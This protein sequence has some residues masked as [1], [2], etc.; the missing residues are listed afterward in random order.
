[1]AYLLLGLKGLVNGYGVTTING[2]PFLLL[3][4]R[5]LILKACNLFYSMA[6]YWQDNKLR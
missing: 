5:T 4:Q 2:M 3:F 1:M 6:A